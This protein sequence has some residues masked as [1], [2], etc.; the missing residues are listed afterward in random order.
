MA[1]GRSQ[2][3]HSVRPAGCRRIFGLVYRKH[4][5]PGDNPYAKGQH[6]DRRLPEISVSGGGDYSLYHIIVGRELRQ[7]LPCFKFEYESTLND[8]LKSLG[9]EVA[10]DHTAVDFSGD[11]FEYEPAL[12]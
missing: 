1:A 9:M 8:A 7:E 12:P 5:Y 10:F 6:R 4:R 3:L 2:H 11:L